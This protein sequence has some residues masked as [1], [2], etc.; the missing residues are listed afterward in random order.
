M[1]ERRPTRGWEGAVRI[2]KDEK[3]LK[4]ADD[5]AL[6]SAPVSVDTSLDTKYV[7]GQRSPYAVLEGS[8][9]ITGSFERPLED[10]LFIRLVGIKEKGPV[11][12][13]EIYTIGI[14][15]QGFGEGKDALVLKNVRFG[16]WSA[17]LAPDD[18]VDESIDWT[19]ED[20][21]FKKCEDVGFEEYTES[22]HI[23]EEE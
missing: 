5:L 8:Q 17:D 18:I 19:G 21:A 12:I 13:P 4:T 20:I 2:A 3:G 11:V 6:Q 22:E 7:I 15:P 16:T 9:D 10:D 1:I 14:F 23:E